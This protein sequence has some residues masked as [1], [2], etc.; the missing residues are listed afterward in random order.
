M[1]ESLGTVKL[2][3]ARKTCTLYRLHE[4]NICIID[5][6]PRG[7]ESAMSFLRDNN[8]DQ[9]LYGAVVGTSVVFQDEASDTASVVPELIYRYAQEKLSV[10]SQ[11]RTLQ[12]I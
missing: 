9:P 12:A 8:L 7:A 11:A 1:I 10:C 3:I 6:G 5:F 2:T 4:P